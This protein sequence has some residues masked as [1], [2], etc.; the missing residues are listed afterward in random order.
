LP[1][2]EFNVFRRSRTE[3]YLAVRKE[4]LG[5]YLAA[6][7]E[8]K[9]AGCAEVGMDFP[10]GNYEYPL[11]AMLGADKGAIRVKHVAVSHPSKI[12]A[13]TASDAAPGSARE[14]RPYAVACL[15]C[16]PERAKLYAAGADQT[17]TQGGLTV[18]IFKD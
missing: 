10:P 13:Q 15:Y 16:P 8:I 4:L 17:L 12:Y 14:S 18:F 6:A 2:A 9:K 11:L 3:L 7:Q 1:T 5:P